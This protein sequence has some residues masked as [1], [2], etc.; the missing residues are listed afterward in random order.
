MVR[1]KV[2]GDNRSAFARKLGLT[3]NRWNN[4]EHG[5][6]VPMSVIFTI[7]KLDI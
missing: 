4:Y 3:V 2:T 6:N 1:T 5:Y 7:I